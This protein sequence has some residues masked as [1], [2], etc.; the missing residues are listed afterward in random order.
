MQFSIY[1]VTF[2]ASNL[3]KSYDKKSEGYDS[4]HRGRRLVL[5]R[6]KRLTQAVQTPT[7]K[8]RVTIPDHG[9]NKD[10]D[11]KTVSSILLQAGIQ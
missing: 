3:K 1:I 2:E 10:L 5:G 9:K 8:G 6:P 11:H 4:N 7:K